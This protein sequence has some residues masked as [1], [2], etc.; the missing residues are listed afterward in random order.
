MNQFGELDINEKTDLAETLKQLNDDTI[1]K[2]TGM[3]GIDMRARLST[4]EIPAIVQ[5]D[6]L[7]GFGVLPDICLNLTRQKKRLSVSLAGLGRREIVK[8]AT[9][10]DEEIVN[11]KRINPNSLM[12]KLLRRPQDGEKQT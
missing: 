4:M 1:D 9:R 11:N 2:D 12:G 6:N 7:V 5:I 8:I 10:Q 3:S